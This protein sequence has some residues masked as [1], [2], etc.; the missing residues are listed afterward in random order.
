MVPAMHMVTAACFRDSAPLN[1]WTNAD[2]DK[3][4]S[5]W[6][7]VQRAAWKLSPGYPSVPLMF[8]GEHGGCPVT[9]PVVPMIQ[10]LATH[11]EQLVALPDELLYTTIR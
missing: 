7:Q 3:L 10:A 4:Y 8:P 5:I 6:M 2:L 9:H 11:I 1:P